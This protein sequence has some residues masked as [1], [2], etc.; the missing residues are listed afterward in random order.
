MAG[1][2]QD[3]ASSSAGR[4]RGIPGEEAARLRAAG[5]IVQFSNGLEQERGSAP[6]AVDGKRESVNG[7]VHEGRGA[8]T[9]V[10]T[11]REVVQDVIDG[12]GCSGCTSLV[13]ELHYCN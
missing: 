1:T 5:L 4:A 8:Y 6:K 12:K 9:T 7:P 3:N 11:F 13:M 10:Y 2:L